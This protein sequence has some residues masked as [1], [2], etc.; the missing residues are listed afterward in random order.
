MEVIGHQAIAEEAE[1][2]ALPGGGEGLEEG[3]AVVIV[4][5]DVGA[6]VAAVDRV[7]GQPFF[8]GSGGSSPG[9]EPIRSEDRRQEK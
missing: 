6:V 2:I 4:H 5:E 1:R 7:V 3:K 8:D 9:G